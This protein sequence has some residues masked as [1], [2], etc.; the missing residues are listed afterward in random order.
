[1]RKGKPALL[2]SQNE[3]FLVCGFFKMTNQKYQ[4]ILNWTRYLNYSN[5]LI[6]NLPVSWAYIDFLSSL[7]DQVVSGVL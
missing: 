3:V 7:I 5:K 4:M 6:S 2:T 1:M